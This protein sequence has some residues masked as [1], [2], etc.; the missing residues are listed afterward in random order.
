MIRDSELQVFEIDVPA[1]STMLS[2]RARAL[3]AGADVDLYLFNCTGKEC[4]TEEFDSNPTVG[5]ERIAIR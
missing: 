1:G 2:V 4:R 3:D 5:E